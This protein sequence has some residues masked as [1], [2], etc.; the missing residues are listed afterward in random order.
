[1]TEYPTV[2]RSFLHVH[3]ASQAFGTG[4][5]LGPI[6]PV[7][8]GFRA[9]S[10]LKV[11]YHTPFREDSNAWGGAYTEL[12]MSVNGGAWESLGCSGYDGGV[13]HYDAYAISHY[14]N[15]LYID[16]ECGVEFSIQFRIYIRCYNATVT[17]NGSHDIDALSGSA[18]YTT[19]PENYYQHYC[20]IIVEEITG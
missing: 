20:H 14:N 18:S 6:T 13:M 5:A 10:K 9:F 2:R 16:P 8:T 11:F 19:N 4:W 1:M 12:Q 15:T 17:L 7:Y 3:T